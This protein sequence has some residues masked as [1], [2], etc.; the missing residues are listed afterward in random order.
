MAEFNEILNQYNQLRLLIDRM[1]EFTDRCC[2]H[3]VKEPVYKLEEAVRYGFP[4][5]VARYYLQVYQD[6]NRM[7]AEA[8]IQ[9]I[10]ERCIPY[11]EGKLA[12]LKGILD[13]LQQ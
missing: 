7:E 10:N 13:L 8:V 2:H 1:H 9:I 3:V 11:L 6:K 5:D 4:V 12:H